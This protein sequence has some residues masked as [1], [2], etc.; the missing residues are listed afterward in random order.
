MSSS[1]CLSE[2]NVRNKPQLQPA[3]PPN[4]RYQPPPNVRPRLCLTSSRPPP[5]PPPP[6]CLA[7]G[8]SKSCPHDSFTRCQSS[9]SRLRR[10]VGANSFEF[11]LGWLL[12]ESPPPWWSTRLGPLSTRWRG[13]CLNNVIPCSH[14][15]DK[16]WRLMA[17]PLHP[18][19]PPGP[20]SFYFFHVAARLA[21][22][23]DR[24]DIF[25]DIVDI[26]NQTSFQAELGIV[27]PPLPFPPSILRLAFGN[28]PLLSS[29]GQGPLRVRVRFSPA[30]W[31]L[32]PRSSKRTRSWSRRI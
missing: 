19:P 5:P 7:A 9:S 28:T 10:R 2:A 31:V 20:S 14:P 32:G 6:C 3:V 18:S 17:F 30:P 16:E 23:F 11:L 15:M 1:A 13:S 4:K 22:R 8:R 27:L 25:V 29:P 26:I 24:R 12:L 21:A